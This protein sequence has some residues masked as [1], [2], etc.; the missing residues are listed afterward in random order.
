MPTAPQSLA[1]NP[2][3]DA[4]QVDEIDYTT[5]FDNLFS[6][7]DDFDKFFKTGKRSYNMLKYIPGLAKLGYHGQLYST[8]AKRMY[9]DDTYKGKKAVEFNVQLMANHYSN[10]QNVHLCFVMKI[11]PAADNNNDIAAGII[12]VN[13]FFAHLIKQ[14]DI[15]RYGDDM[16][17]L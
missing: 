12:T 5:D 1:L 6:R 13:S 3:K 14:I 8:E 15:K 2:L 11:K 7:R 10:F 16:P 9:A 4:A 17:I